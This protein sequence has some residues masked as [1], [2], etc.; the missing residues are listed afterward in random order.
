MV[1]KK[2]DKNLI[3]LESKIGESLNSIKPSDEFNK[4]MLKQFSESSRDSNKFSLHDFFL[5]KKNVFAFTALAILGIIF[6]MGFY[7]WSNS[8]LGLNPKTDIADIKN[9]DEVEQ[10]N[11]T[12]QELNYRNIDTSGWRTERLK[13][14]PE[15]TMEIKVPADWILNFYNNGNTY[16]IVSPS[17]SA[18]GYDFF[19]PTSL[20]DCTGKNLVG[21]N[22]NFSRYFDD[23]SYPET[24]WYICE[25]INGKMQM[26]WGKSFSFY[27]KSQSDLAILDAI[28]AS[29]VKI[30]QPGVTGITVTPTPVS[31]NNSKVTFR[32]N[33]DN[34]KYLIE[35]GN[36]GSVSTSTIDNQFFVDA[37]DG[38][39]VITFSPSSF[40]HSY[41]NDG[42]EIIG[43]ISEQIY[44]TDIMGI[45]Y[46][47]DPDPN[48]DDCKIDGI[49]V[50]IDLYF[51]SGI[52]GSFQAK[53]NS[54]TDSE[55]PPGAHSSEIF[56]KMIASFTIKEI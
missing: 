20:V 32:Y 1:N 23:S 37:S 30:H 3:M 29:F 44:K 33:Y 28:M 56:D 5:M 40:E 12:P 47:G 36:Y 6:V 46:V 15:S 19:I 50:C 17:G 39:L 8:K 42:G 34:K 41:G 55:A 22:D 54:I 26:H 35:M 43:K 13:Y 52:E 10:R 38:R 31:G 21:I 11:E 25:M 7:A 9:G 2:M 45:N 24:N 14:D 18:W 51:Y 4:K 53:A 16:A 49:E 48:S 27:A